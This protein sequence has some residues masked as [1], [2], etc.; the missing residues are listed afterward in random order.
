VR[1]NACWCEITILRKEKQVLNM[2]NVLL[3]LHVR[4]NIIFKYQFLHKK[5][6]S[7][8]GA[9]FEGKE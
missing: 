4:I 3:E 6:W 1:E 2:Q 5:N 7:N 8:E 9:K